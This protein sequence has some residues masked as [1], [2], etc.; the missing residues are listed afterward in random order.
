MVG[1]QVLSSRA[2][3]I[4]A[5]EIGHIGLWAASQLNEWRMSREPLSQEKRGWLRAEPWGG[6]RSRDGWKEEWMKQLEK[7]QLEVRVETERR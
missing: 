2:R 1:I 5:V 4:L 6:L 3:E 7:E